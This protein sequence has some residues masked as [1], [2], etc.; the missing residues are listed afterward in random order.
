MSDVIKEE[1]SR[2]SVVAI[3]EMKISRPLN[4]F[5]TKKQNSLFKKNNEVSKEILTV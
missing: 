3:E 2:G 1:Q 5:R 4:D